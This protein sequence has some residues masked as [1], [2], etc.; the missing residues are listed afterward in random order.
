MSD[1]N[2]NEKRDLQAECSRARFFQCIKNPAFT[3]CL[4]NASVEQLNCGDCDFCL[5]IKTAR[6]TVEKFEKAEPTNSEE[7]TLLEMAKALVVSSEFISDDHE[8]FIENCLSLRRDI[9]IDVYCG[10][11]SLAAIEN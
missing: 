5:A 10:R 3:A 1:K 6:A 9:L 11:C 7:K 8:H 2:G 4:Q